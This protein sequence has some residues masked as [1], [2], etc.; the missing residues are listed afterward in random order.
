MTASDIKHSKISVVIFQHSGYK[1]CAM[2][3][4][5]LCMIG[6]LL[7]A[8]IYEAV[9]TIITNLIIRKCVIINGCKTMVRIMFSEVAAIAPWF[10]L[11]LPSCSPRFES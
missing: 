1:V 11:C 6:T 10:C 8:V 5:R 9:K 3:V 7:Y 4:R 2:V